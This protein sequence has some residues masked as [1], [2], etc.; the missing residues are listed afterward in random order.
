M[1]V[2]KG[3]IIFVVV[4][5]VLTVSASFYIYQILY[6]PNIQVGKEERIVLIPKDADFKYIQELFFDEDI[7][8]DPVSFSFIAR[9]M[10]YDRSIKPGRYKL[11]AN[12]SNVEAIRLLRSGEQ[13]PLNITFNNIRLK[14]DLAQK[15]TKNIEVDS[16]TFLKALN[17]FVVEESEWNDE[18]I[19]CLF[20]PNT[21]QVY[22]TITAEDLIER[23]EY[24]HSNFW[25]ESRIAKAAE[26]GLEV[27][28]VCAL[29]SIVQAETKII[30]ESPT[31][32][33]LYLNRIRRN[34]YLQADPTLVYAA[35]DFTIKRVLNEH[36]EI[37]SPY[38]TYMYKGLPPGPINL[39]EIW[40][41]NAVLEDRQHRF[42]YM[43]AKEDFSGYHNFATNL[44]EHNANAAR[45]QR[46][47]SIE[48]RKARMNVD[49]L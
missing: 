35:G 28:E 26:L 10:K 2:K 7:A 39:P 13:E 3:F 48:Q 29:A 21:Y 22:W 11:P 25:N 38:N 43:C 41:L 27:N 12:S 16:A 14:E 37:D 15:I 17:N 44:R 34:M 49:R 23:M 1:K 4:A 30:E 33:G 24:E 46:A 40:A 19:L 42:L 20:V 6:S 32:A 45:Y 5:T 31:I 9:L 36:K 47:L 8:Q 18:N